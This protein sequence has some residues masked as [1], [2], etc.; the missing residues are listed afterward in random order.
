MTTIDDLPVC[1]W[2]KRGTTPQRLVTAWVNTRRNRR[3]HAHAA[4]VDR[5]DKKPI[6]PDPLVNRRRKIPS[7]AQRLSEWNALADDLD[8]LLAQCRSAPLAL[9]TMKVACSVW[10]NV[11]GR[12]TDMAWALVGP[13]RP[14]EAGDQVRRLRWHVERL[15]VALVHDSSLRRR[16]GVCNIESPDL[17]PPDTVKAVDAVHEREFEEFM[18]ETAPESQPASRLCGVGHD[19]RHRRAI[20][21]GTGLAE[22]LRRQ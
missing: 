12:K 9:S 20:Q 7:L 13:N 17:R 5:N 4:C 16:N 22:L 1:V 10:N 18:V 14:D 3:Y 11:H 6:P 2:C 15:R 19:V 21:S 8:R